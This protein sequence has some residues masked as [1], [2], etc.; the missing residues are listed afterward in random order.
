MTSTS[1]RQSC[2]YGAPRAG[3]RACTRSVAESCAPCG[4]CSVKHPKAPTCSFPS[5]WRRSAWLA[6]SAWSR[7]LARPPASR[8]C[9]TRT[10]CGIPAAT[11]SP[12]TARI[13]ARSSTTS[14]TARS[15]RRCATRRWRLTAL[16][17]SGK[18]DAGTRGFG[19]RRPGT[20]RGGWHCRRRGRDRVKSP[21]DETLTA[22]M[23]AR[24]V[25]HA[26]R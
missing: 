26:N 5:A 19:Q 25:S 4:G 2:T 16:K 15:I 12:M 20:L 14:A 24:M 9:C 8:S 17:A 21:G 22:P 10:C 6:I 23:R 7:G 18:I 3:L 1:P 11:S 13:R